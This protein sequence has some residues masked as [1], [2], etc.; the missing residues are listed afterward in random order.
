M[1]F[2]FLCFCVQV[3]FGFEL[4]SLTLKKRFTNNIKIVLSAP[5]GIASSTLCFFVFSFILGTNIVHLLLHIAGLSFLS[6]L[7]FSRRRKQKYFIMEKPS[8]TTL[9]EVILCIFV[10]IFFIFSTYFP[11][12]QTICKVCI[13]LFYHI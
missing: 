4:A 3:W 6:S 9:V 5:I 8:R 2:G 1:L 11:E 10:S 12:K 13:S 7:L